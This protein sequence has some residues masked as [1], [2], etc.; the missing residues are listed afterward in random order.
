M[1]Y[2]YISITTSVLVV[3][4]YI[5]EIYI[6]IVNK[7]SDLSNTPIWIIWLIASALGVIYC[8]LNQY[9]IIMINYLLNFFLCGLSCLCII[10]FRYN[11]LI[12]NNYNNDKLVQAKLETITNNV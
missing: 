11:K 9:Y 3:I 2:E 12:E 8:G 6:I 5:P 10:Y 7:R 4:G 1:V